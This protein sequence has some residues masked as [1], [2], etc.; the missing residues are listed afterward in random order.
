[1]GTL[2]AELKAGAATAGEGAADVDAAEPSA[3]TT[4]D[5]TERLNRKQIRGSGLLLTGRGF[6]GVLKFAAELMVVRYLTTE[7]YGSWTWALSA[8]LLLQNF[9]TMGLNRA[10][11]RF[12]PIHLEH[13]ERDELFGVLAFVLGSLLLAGALLVTAFYAFPSAIAGLAGASPGQP[14][15]ILFIVIFLVPVEAIS[16]FFTGVCAAFGNS[17][18]IFVRRY[19]LH[20]GLRLAVALIL[21]V[22]EADV[23]VLAWGYLLSGLAGVLYYSVTVYGELRRNGLL[24][25]K[26][27]TGLR[28]PVR[29]V[30]SYTMPVMGADWFRSL[31]VT[32]APLLL[33]YYTDMSA[34]ALYQV[35]IPLVALNAL[36]SQ[37]FAMMFEPSASRILARDDRS[38]LEQLYWRSAVWVAV[39]SFPGFAVSFAA[40]EPLTV[41][42]FG[43]RYAAAAPILSLLAIGTFVDA[44]A[45]FNDATLRVA[46]RVRWLM[47]VNAGGAL[48]NI[49][50]NLLLIPRM[51]AL[52]AGIATGSALLAYAVMKQ[53][54][55]WRATGV[56]V[57]PP[58]YVR[59]YGIMALLTAGL[60]ILR[61]Q[62]GDDLWIVLPGVTLAVLAVAWLAR[63]TLSVSETFPEIARWPLIKRIVG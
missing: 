26:F 55:L 59:P 3:P 23:R 17:R 35:V 53:L 7:A 27:S 9:S 46:G 25:G 28:L 1:V 63:G 12:A 61:L 15:D 56:R 57:L 45:G 8:V 11:A 13:R 62:W 33:G 30:L 42:L 31:M 50:L 47:G 60:V 6:A 39:L 58:G 40:A 29:R 38:G 52:G 49:G 16:G 22:L 19:V 14:L 5:S 44:S 4:T 37:S 34:V 41:L 51:G 32:P 43:D 24:A 48:L 54:C 10:V 20:P 36:A 21:V 18:A 2:Q